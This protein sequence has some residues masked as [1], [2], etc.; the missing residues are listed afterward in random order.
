[1]DNLTLALDAFVRSVRVNANVRHAFFL[2]AG[3]SV[4]SGVPSA[5]A[6]V[7]EW[8]REIFLSNNPGLEDQFAELTLPAVQEKIQR[9]LDARAGF[10][11][12]GSAEE[13]AFYVERC[14][15]VEEH[16]R[17]WFQQKIKGVR[18]HVGYRMLGALAEA[19]VVDSVWSTN[20]DRLSSIAANEFRITPI[21]IGFDSSQRLGRSLR[22]DELLVVALH[23]DYRYDRLCNTPED[24]RATDGE[25]RAAL[26]ERIPSRPLIVC[27]Y[28]GRDDSVMEA[29]RQAYSRKGSGAIYWCTRGEESPRASV[30]ELI[31]LA[32][33][34]G[35]AGYIVPSHGFDDLMS[36][37]ALGCLDLKSY[38]GV[39]AAAAAGLEEALAREPF[40]TERVEVGSLIKSN[41]FEITCPTA[42]HEFELAKWPTRGNVWSWLREQAEGHDLVVAPS[43][44]RVLCIGSTDAIRRAFGAQLKGDIRRTPIGD[45]ELRHADGAVTSLLVEGLVRSIAA[46]RGL[47]TDGRKC[48][49][50]EAI[51][52]TRQFEG[53]RIE[54]R[55]SAIVFL[56]R[57]GRTEFMVLKP[58]VQVSAVGGGALPEDVERRARLNVLGWQHNNK[59]NAAMDAWRSR[60]FPEKDGRFAFPGTGEITYEVRPTPAFAA[61][62]TRGQRGGRISDGASRHVKHT[63]F[64]IA[65]PRLLFGIRDG[66]PARDVHP[67]RGVLANKP[68]DHSLTQLGISPAVRVGVVAPAK[69]AQRLAA[70]LGRSATRL[71][72]LHN[73]RD[74]LVDYP[75]FESAFGLPIEIPE[76]GGPGWVTYPEPDAGSDSRAGS[77]EL[78]RNLTA[79]IDA[80]TASRWPCVAL[81]YVPDRLMRWRG[82]ETEDEKFDLHDFTKAHC[83][84][85]GIAS[86]FLNEHTLNEDQQCRVQWWLSLALYVKSMRTP[87]LLE[88]LDQNTAFIGLGF[89]IDRKAER[90]RHV[91]LGCSHIYSAR[92]EGLQYRLSKIEDPTIRRG[93]AFMSY[94]DA[95]RIGETARELFYESRMRLPDRVVVHKQT[96]FLSDERKGLIEGLGGVAEVDLLEITIEKAMRY[97]ASAAG[98]TRSDNYPVERGSAVRLDRHSA[99]LWVHGVAS[100]LNPTFRYYQGKRRIP[101]PL[102]IKRHAGK[103]DLRV[104][105]SEIL[106]LSKMDWN[107]FDLYTKLPSTIASS[108]YIAR[109]GSLLDRFAA[110][111]HDY[112]LF[113]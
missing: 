91:V 76:P 64:E 105:C 74:Y 7:W 30:E 79:G 111:L 26:I 89:S 100:A 82:F 54:V 1:M 72:P 51:S 106:G 58:S 112:R 5:D 96:P 4:S 93:N 77:L 87:W 13:Y 49:W 97:V 50:M 16:R 65:E 56:R 113:I 68:F 107:S 43:R 110:R 27:G 46:K 52:E 10:P 17:A 38:A 14:F 39:R 90:G 53:R 109:V 3:A 20:F 81:V 75:G 55:E 45:E 92:G 78:A 31:R 101:A 66:Q 24:M 29:L 21:E 48:L 60:V 108:G 44:G 73:E 34:N 18:P 98:G 8:K 11:A 88:G 6:C 63:G 71:Q 62:A 22:N 35:Y 9:W 2:G 25:L 67:I 37:L 36:R 104:V 23:G 99:L 85:R 40:T 33:E 69:D 84:T 102:V 95:R 94:D 61:L 103:S 41:A 57:I 32:R 15:P 28:S 80:L 83:V 12:L 42:V 86:Q 59:F 19:S 47:Q 70:F